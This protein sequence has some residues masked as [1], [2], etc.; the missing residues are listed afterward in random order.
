MAS[1]PQ[2]NGLQRKLIIA[3]DVG[4]TYSGAAYAV[5][6]PGIIPEI[7]NVTRYPGQENAV[8]DTKIP[9]VLYYNP[10][11]TIHSVGAETDQPGMALI[12]EDEDLIL[13]EWFKLHL[14][15]DSLASD[16]LNKKTIPPLPPNKTVV[17]VFAD[18]LRYLYACTKRYIVETHANGASLWAS[19]ES[20]IESVLSHPNGWEGPQ[21]Q[22]MR[23]AAILAGLIPDSPSGK[24][25][26]NFVTEGEASLYFCVRNGLV[27]D[28]LRDGQSVLI[29]DAGGGTVDLSAYKFVSMS[30]LSVEEVATPECLIQGSTRVDARAREFLEGL[31]ASLLFED[32][33]TM[34]DFF[35]KSTKPVFKD[36]NEPSYIKFGTM[37]SNDPMFQIRRGQLVLPGHDVASF[38]EPSITAIVDAIQTQRQDIFPPLINVFLVG[39]FAASPWLFSRLQN[40]LSQHGMSLARP[41]RHTNKAVAEG[42]VAFFLTNWVSVRVARMTYGTECSRQYNADDPEHFLRRATVVNRPSGRRMIPEAFSVLLSKG[43]RVRENDEV[44]QSFCKEATATSKLRNL[45][46]EITCYRGKNKNPRWIDT[47]PGI[48]CKQSG[49]NGFYYTQEY[50][51]VLFCGLAELKAQIVWTE[52]VSNRSCYST[53][54]YDDDAE[55]LN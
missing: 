18:F 32:I 40:T 36:S 23:R 17:E 53:I 15:P 46:S 33:Q 44:Y 16:E 42:A 51:I 4:T 55:A 35:R 30:P 13:V 11:G 9:S 22:Q 37:S 54:V 34:M 5:L 20:T 50:K 29:V 45:T 8:G 52:N 19:V 38:F 31:V 21:Q 28:S 39:G 3:F 7:K 6:D 41:D 49:P 25:R 24:S 43:T 10:D 12:A 14:R 27:S 1:L 47:E 48:N 2:Y 26:I